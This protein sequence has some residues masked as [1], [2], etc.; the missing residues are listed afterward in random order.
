MGKVCI[1]VHLVE[2]NQ[3]KKKKIKIVCHFHTTSENDLLDHLDK[4]G[5]VCNNIPYWIAENIFSILNNFID[6][7]D[8]VLVF[9]FFLCMIKI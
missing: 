9:L 3:T 8:F 2:I 6:Q 5:L 4:S 7:D 1:S